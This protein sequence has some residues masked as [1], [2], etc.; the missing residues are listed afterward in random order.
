[1]S[2]A[3]VIEE[4]KQRVYEANMELPNLDLVKLTWGN[5]SEINRELGVI[6]IKPSGVP[7]KSMTKEQMVVTDL[8]GILLEKDSLKPSSDLA[9]HVVLYKNFET[10]N[11]VVHTHSTNAVMWAQSGFDLKAYGTTHADTFYGSVPCTRQLTEDEVRNDYEENTGNVIIETF[12]E[13]KLKPEEVPGVLVSGHGPF[14]WGE[15]PLKAVENSLILDEVCLMA[16]ETELINQ[17]I[18]SIP[19]YL[20]DKH[21]LRKHGKNA[22][23]GQ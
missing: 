8:K 6:V 9:T 2:R 21:Y 23:Y 17:R 13:R 5:V 1:M 7:Y 20:L 14:T 3:D 15:T 4:M 12:L 10:V 22:Y 18:S 19:S 11:A 16:K